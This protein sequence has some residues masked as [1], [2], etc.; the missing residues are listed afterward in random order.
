MNGYYKMWKAYERSGSEPSHQ[1]TVD[2]GA[3]NFY[4]KKQADGT[5]IRSG[6]KNIQPVPVKDCV[7]ETK[8]LGDHRVYNLTFARTFLEWVSQILYPRHHPLQF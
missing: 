8:S 7:L 2:E 1:L 3:Q 6:D 4:L 5:K